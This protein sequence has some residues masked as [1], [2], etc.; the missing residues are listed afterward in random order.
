MIDTYIKFIKAHETVLGIVLAAFVIYGGVS[1]VEDRLASRDNL[2]FKQAVI[3]SDNQAKADAAVAAQVAADKTALDALTT[4]LTSANDALAKANS[5]LEAALAKQQQQDNQ[6]TPSELTDRWNVLVP[7]ANA[8]V[9]PNGVTLPAAGAHATVDQLEQ[10]PVLTQELSNSKQS[11]Q[12]T[13]TL[14]GASQKQVTDLNSEVSGLNLQLVDNQKVCTAQ[15]AV[16]KADAA[17]AK[18]RWFLTGLV[19]GFLGRSAIK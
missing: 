14:L 9:T 11:E 4:K 2:Q 18:R 1:M 16:V 10:I 12:N 3:V 8:A 5:A 7:T 6:M 19:L 15:I 13:D 17:K